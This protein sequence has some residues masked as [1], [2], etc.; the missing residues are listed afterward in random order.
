[1]NPFEEM[2][3][4]EITSDDASAEEQM[5]FEAREGKALTDEHFHDLPD[6]YDA[7]NEIIETLKP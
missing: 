3:D 7:H 1:M 4:R 5:I 6:N 2:Q